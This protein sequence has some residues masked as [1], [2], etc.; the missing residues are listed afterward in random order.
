MLNYTELQ[1]RVV[2]CVT[3]VQGAGKT[4][5][6]TLWAYLFAHNSYK[7]KMHNASVKFL[8]QNN[9]RCDNTQRIIPS[10]NI[11][12]NGRFTNVEKFNADNEIL[13]IFDNKRFIAEHTMLILDEAQDKFNSRFWQQTGRAPARFC[14]FAR[15]YNLNI[16]FSCQD[17]FM[18]DKTFRAYAKIYWID[19]CY[20][21]DVYN[22]KHLCTPNSPKIKAVD[23]SKIVYLYHTF[24]N[25][26]QYEKFFSQNALTKTLTQ[27]K[28]EIEANIFNMYNSSYLKTEFMKKN[29]GKK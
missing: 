22:K 18:I 13:D 8:L 19:A 25:S 20:I 23:I 29:D 14:E 26:H 6:L 2:N 3:G 11:E 24:E 1:P 15:H 16:I 5:F 9:Y 21:V 10:Y 4:A 7:E 12:L 27:K 17:F 28:I